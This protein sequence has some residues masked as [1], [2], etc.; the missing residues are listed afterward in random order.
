VGGCGTATVSISLSVPQ[1]KAGTTS[2]HATASSN[3]LARERVGCITTRTS[4]KTR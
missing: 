2:V 1:A 3:T 4:A